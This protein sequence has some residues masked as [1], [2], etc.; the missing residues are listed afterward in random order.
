LVENALAGIANVSAAICSGKIRFLLTSPD[1]L[2][3]VRYF[4]PDR[5]FGL[6][7]CVDLLVV[8]VRDSRELF[9]E[10][11]NAAESR[12][13]RIFLHAV[14]PGDVTSELLAVIEELNDGVC[15]LTLLHSKRAGFS[16]IQQI[17]NIVVSIRDLSAI[18][19]PCMQ[20]S[21]CHIA[22]P[23]V[24]NYELRPPAERAST[25]LHHLHSP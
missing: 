13:I 21:D 25:R 5:L 12:S 1:R 8:T 23:L 9:S 2:K 22:R 19:D 17:R 7:N 4:D 11:M 14:F 20:T 18:L 10:V 24:A 3:N 6:Q 15:C 16:S